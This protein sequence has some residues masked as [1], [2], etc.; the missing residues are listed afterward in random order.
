LLTVSPEQ[1]EE[2][3][4]RL[5]VIQ[6]LAEQARRTTADVVKAAEM[7]G[8]AVAQAYRMLRR[9]LA[10]PRLT[11]LIPQARGGMRGRSRIREEL[12]LL[13]DEVIESM[14]L[15]KQR[16]QE[17]GPEESGISDCRYGSLGF[18]AWLLED[19]P[20]G[21]G[22]RVARELLSRWFTGDR[23]DIS[24]HL[25]RKWARSSELDVHQMSSDT[26][27]RL[28]NLFDS[29][30]IRADGAGSLRSL[31]VGSSL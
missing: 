18:L 23:R 31:S 1:W 15:T 24:R 21:A 14:Y 30:R 26:W 7:L 22:A 27:G 16:A 17:L 19:W 8:V 29:T 13:I 4:R 11:S 25:G 6:P 9:Y 28:W 3:R 5:I 2:A 12:N 20:D 10:D